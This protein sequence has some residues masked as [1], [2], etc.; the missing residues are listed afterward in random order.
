MN[1]PRFTA[2][3]SLYQSS[4]PYRSVTAWAYRIGEYG[5]L[6]QAQIC[7]GCQPDSNSRTGC[8]IE[9][10]TD[11]TGQNCT[12]RACPCPPPP[13]VC[14]PCLLPTSQLR[15]QILSGQPIDPA[16]L[17]FQQTCQQGANSFTLSCE[18]CSRETKIS[19]P[20]PLSD[21][22]IQVCTS[23]FDPDSFRVSV[24]DC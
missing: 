9:C 1:M 19:L 23:G 15:Q 18:R 4:Q 12:T 22:C 10:C 24:R 5:I 6:A 11:E 2:G 3:V 14:G 13:T 7:F 20:W 21:K 17:T 8:S 16:T